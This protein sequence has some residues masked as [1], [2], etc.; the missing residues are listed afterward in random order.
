MAAINPS[1]KRELDELVSQ[2]I[3]AFK[4]DGTMDDSDVFEYRLRHS[5]I[6]ALYREMDRIVRTM[7]RTQGWLGPQT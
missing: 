7:Q 5:R 4:N 3:Q 1:H 6:M 2:Q